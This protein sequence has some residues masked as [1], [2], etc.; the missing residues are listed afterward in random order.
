MIDDV[1]PEQIPAIT[2]FADVQALPPDEPTA[3][4]L[5]GTNQVPP[6]D[7]VAERYHRGLA[8]LIIATGG[9]N[10]RNQI[11]EGQVFGERIH[12]LPLSPDLLTF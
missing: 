5:F 11:V 7:I 8:P 12:S 4:F 9:V 6:V 3:C 2:R 1:N 10:R